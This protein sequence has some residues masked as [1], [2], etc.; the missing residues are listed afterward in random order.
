MI[1]WHAHVSTVVVCLALAVFVASWSRDLLNGELFIKP[2][3]RRITWKSRRT[4]DSL[5]ILYFTIFIGSVRRSEFNQVMNWR[6]CCIVVV[7]NLTLCCTCRASAFAAAAAALQM[8]S[9]PRFFLPQSLALATLIYW[10]ADK[11]ATPA[12]GLLID[13][14]ERDTTTRRVCLPRPID[15]Q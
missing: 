14:K 4:R 13:K 6:G 15:S 12:C 2:I 3:K 10:L 7:V 8:S 5:V 11:Q 1:N 9:Q